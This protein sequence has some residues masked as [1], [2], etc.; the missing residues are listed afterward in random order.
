MLPFIRRVLLG[1]P[2]RLGRWGERRSCRYLKG[3]G[4]RLITQNFR[5]NSGEVDIVMADGDSLVF[6]EVKT[7]RNEN[8]ASAQS[9]VNS[10]KRQRLTRAANRFVRQYKITN[11]PLRFDVMAVVL[12]DKGSPEIRHYKNAFVP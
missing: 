5:C 8:V 12:G 2:K 4:Y 1:D 3:K 6:V 7:R 10:N 9:A 11:K